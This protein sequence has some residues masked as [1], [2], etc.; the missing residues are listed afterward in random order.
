VA[1]LAGGVTA[2]V[3]LDEG[4]EHRGTELE[5]LGFGAL[6]AL[7]LACAERAE[8]DALLTT[9]DALLRRAR[10]HEDRLRV[11]VDDPLAWMNERS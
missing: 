6:D 11:P 3:P 5:A 2:T 10:R 1:V 7:H 8:V 4:V 9:D